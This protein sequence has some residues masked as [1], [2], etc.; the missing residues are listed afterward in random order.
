MRKSTKAEE[1]TEVIFFYNHTRC[2][3]KVVDELSENVRRLGRMDGYELYQID[4]LFFD[5]FGF[6]VVKN[7]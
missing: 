6:A 4:S 1:R 5:Q 7:H 3:A 2:H